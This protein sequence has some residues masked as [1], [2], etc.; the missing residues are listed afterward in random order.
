MLWRL[1]LL[2]SILL[3]ALSARA[4]YSAPRLM[5][6]GKR[7]T[8]QSQWV[9]EPGDLPPAAI[10][11]ETLTGPWNLSESALPDDATPVARVAGVTR[12]TL[13]ALTLLENPGQRVTRTVALPP[14]TRYSLR[15]LLPFVGDGEVR[16]KFRLP[17]GFVGQ[18]KKLSVGPGDDSAFFCETERFGD[19]TAPRGIRYAPPTL[20]DG[21][22]VRFVTRATNDDGRIFT[23][24][25]WFVL[26][27]KRGQTHGFTLPQAAGTEQTQRLPASKNTKIRDGFLR[28]I[29]EATTLSFALHGSP[30]ALA[31]TLRSD[32][33][34][35][36]TVSE[37]AR[38][39]GRRTWRP[40]L[41]LVFGD[42][43]STL[44]G[45][46]RAIP[47]ALG[48]TDSMPGR[49]YVGFD[50]PAVVDG[51]TAGVF[52]DALRAGK[53]VREATSSAQSYYDAHHFLDG[54]TYP[55]TLRIVGDPEAR[56]IG[57]WELI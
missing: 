15:V 22:L 52:W 26:Y 40:P 32:D 20:S 42:S 48:I 49:A 29:R 41:Q 38:A 45:G 7:I 16:Y 18:V 8:A 56:L 34:Q 3:G 24:E 43:C 47:E 25:D 5:Y 1:L 4:E 27:Q 46:A 11:E 33:P 50:A 9:G 51:R 2:F 44:A 21:K 35:K 13:R 14:G 57:S 12:T 55:A 39:S 6:Q 17:T 28:Q 31:P 19:P 10:L 54:K 30:T 36:I 37:M 53:T 23:D